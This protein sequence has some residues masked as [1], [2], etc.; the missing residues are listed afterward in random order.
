MSAE[1][2][3]TNCQWYARAPKYF[4]DPYEKEHG[5]EGRCRFNPPY[6]NGWPITYGSYWCASWQ[7][8]ERGPVT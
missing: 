3:C 4:D 5:W 6:H 2:T 1:Q 8:R 7:K